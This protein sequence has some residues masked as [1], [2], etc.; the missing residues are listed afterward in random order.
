M[1][2]ARTLGCNVR[3]VA[4]RSQSLSGVLRPEGILLHLGENIILSLTPPLAERI[5]WDARPAAFGSLCGLRL[6][7]PVFWLMNIPRQCQVAWRTS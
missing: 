7:D 2:G 3:G 1:S 4:G 6:S 5:I